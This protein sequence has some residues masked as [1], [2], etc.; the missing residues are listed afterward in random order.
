MSGVGIK[1]WKGGV[2]LK[3]EPQR[4]KNLNFLKTNLIL[5]LF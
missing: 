3:A 5:G 4:S 1:I 2:V